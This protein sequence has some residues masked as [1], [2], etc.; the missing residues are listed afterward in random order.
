MNSQAKPGNLPWRLRRFYLVAKQ[1]FLIRSWL[2]MFGVDDLSGGFPIEVY[3]KKMKKYHF[4]DFY[5]E[6]E[7]K[8]VYCFFEIKP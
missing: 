7:I 4:Y 3:M 6:Y 1:R 2:Q 8:C 5:L